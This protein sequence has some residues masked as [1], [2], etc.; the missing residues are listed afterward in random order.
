MPTDVL[1]DRVLARLQSRKERK[2]LRKLTEPSNLIDFSSND[3]LGL[4]KHPALRARFLERVSSSHDLLG[5]GGSRLLDG[6]TS[7]HVVLEQRLAAFFAAPAALLFG[8]GY[9]ANV[10]FFSCVPQKG[11]V[12]VYDALIH[13]SVHDGM[14]ASRVPKTD[15]IPFQHNTVASLRGIIT[16]SLEKKP[17]IADGKSAMWIAVES[18]YS[19]DG[20]FAPLADIVNAVEEL[21]PLGNGYIIVDEAHSTGIYGPNGKGLISMLGLENRVFARLHTFGKALASNGAVFLT[22]PWLREYLI[23][24]AR[25]LIYTTALAGYNAIAAQS[26]F[27]ILETS[28]GQELSR[29]VQSLSSHFQTRLRGFLRTRP[30]SSLILPPSAPSISPTHTI[31]SPIVPLLTPHPRELSQFLREECG[32]LARPITHPTVP[33]G[34]E[35]VRVCIHANNTRE[36]VD[37]LVEGVQEWIRSQNGAASSPLT[38]IAL[39][40]RAKL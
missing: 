24:Y 18:L 14:R 16:A 29:H 27:D 4:S 26:S 6:N 40:A 11:D 10:G 20:D 39:G 19:M 31:I 3:Y 36:Q 32:I 9:D 1:R 37:R 8:S 5:A 28:L 38:P 7:E 35:R 17:S 33:K 25:P 30:N 21:L 13:A 34:E 12:I 15:C 2:I 22:T 23:N